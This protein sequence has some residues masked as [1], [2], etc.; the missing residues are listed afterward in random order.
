MKFLLSSCSF[1]YAVVNV[2]CKLTFGWNISNEGMEFGDNRELFVVFKR[3]EEDYY[4]KMVEG[5]ALF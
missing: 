4:W 2:H 3:C 5:E 1:W